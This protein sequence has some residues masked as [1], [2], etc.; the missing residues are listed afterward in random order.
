MSEHRYHHRRGFTLIELAV[1]VL[2]I[3][4]LIS[5]IM[6]GESLI[7]E[8]R[9]QDALTLAAD[10]SAASRAFKQRYHYLP[11]DFSVTKDS[12]EIPNVSDACKSGGTNAGNGN[13]IIDANEVA[14]VPEHLFAS[15]FIKGGTGPMRTHFG[16]LKVVANAGSKTALGPNPLPPS[17]QNVIEFANLPCEVAQEIDRKIDDGNLAM[18]NARASLAACTPKSATDPVPFFAIPL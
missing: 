2:V 3:G 14:C 7:Q 13:G 9:V 5:A 17:V 4:I 8:S 1:V 6:K 11:G 12:P 16:D 15:G 18:G 10:L